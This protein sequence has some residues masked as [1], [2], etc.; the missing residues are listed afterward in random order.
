MDIHI[1]LVGMRDVLTHAV[2][3]VPDSWICKTD[4]IY[5]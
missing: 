4:R 3:P 5:L 2:A 1:G